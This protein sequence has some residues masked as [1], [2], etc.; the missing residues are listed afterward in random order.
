M[1]QKKK[2]IIKIYYLNWL[3][4]KRNISSTKYNGWV[5]YAKFKDKD[6]V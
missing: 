6:S 1:L 4:I 2:C 3:K 5:E